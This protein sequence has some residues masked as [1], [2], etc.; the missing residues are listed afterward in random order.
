MAVFPAQFSKM[1]FELRHPM[2]LLTNDFVG[3][4]T[5]LCPAEGNRPPHLNVRNHSRLWGNC[6]HFFTNHLLLHHIM[7]DNN[8][9]HFC[10]ICHVSLIIQTPTVVASAP[11]PPSPPRNGNKFYILNF[12]HVYVALD[13]GSA[14]V[15]G[16]LLGD[17][18]FIQ[19]LVPHV[20]HITC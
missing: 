8:L 3:L 11:T 17:Q 12:L 5:C 6:T 15:G 1:F 18:V 7:L 10:K 19:F 16:E 2:L 14:P 9:F 20:A 13:Q 4:K